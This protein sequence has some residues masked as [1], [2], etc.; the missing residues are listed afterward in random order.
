MPRPADLP[1]V[2]PHGR[3][4]PITPAEILRLAVGEPVPGLADRPQNSAAKSRRERPGA[5]RWSSAARSSVSLQG[6]GT[7]GDARRERR[8]VLDG[9]LRIRHLIQL[10]EVEG[11]E[12]APQA[13]TAA[14]ATTAVAR[15]VVRVTAGAGWWRR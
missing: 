3:L 11:R 2:H 8:Q 5:S 14:I 12:Q 15:R 7:Y 4:R 6:R 1:M 10:A 9:Y 13:G